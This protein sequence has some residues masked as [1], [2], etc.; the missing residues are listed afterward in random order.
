[1]AW[2]AQEYKQCDG[3]TAGDL[4]IG[5]TGRHPDAPTTSMNGRQKAE[6]LGRYFD[7]QPDFPELA[8]NLSKL[9]K[10]PIPPIKLSPGTL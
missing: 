5:R 3:R 4:K 7:L 1:M 10:L 9:D 6:A 8:F 2:A